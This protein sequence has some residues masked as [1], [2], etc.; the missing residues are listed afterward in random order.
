MSRHPQRSPARLTATADVIQVSVPRTLSTPVVTTFSPMSGVLLRTEH[1]TWVT[2]ERVG[3]LVRRVVFKTS[4]TTVFTP[5]VA[6]AVLGFEVFIP[7]YLL[8]RLISLVTCD[9][10][11]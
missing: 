11:M 1:G 7:D 4:S 6:S 10:L 3:F 5:Y 8:T 9:L 2:E